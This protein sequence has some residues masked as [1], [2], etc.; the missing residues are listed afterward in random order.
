[1][2]DLT[3][4]KNRIKISAVG[5]GGEGFENKRY[6]ECEAIIDCAFKEVIN[7]R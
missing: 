1:M 5:I 2:L 4:V 6:E 3:L 7:L